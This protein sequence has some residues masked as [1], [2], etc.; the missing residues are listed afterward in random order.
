MN[1]FSQNF[2]LHKQLHFKNRFLY[3]I[4]FS[5]VVALISILFSCLYSY[6]YSK[7]IEVNITTSDQVLLHEVE[8]SI[9]EV[10]DQIENAG[11]Q[12]ALSVTRLINKSKLSLTKDYSRMQQIINSLVNL[13][14]SNSY[15]HSSYVYISSGNMVMTSTVGTIPF[16]LFYDTN[17]KS[18]YDKNT[19]KIT[20]IGP[21]KPY[22]SKMAIYEP[23]YIKNGFDDK[24]VITMI[25]P[26]T[27][28]PSIKGGA[29]IINLY[30]EKI[31]ELMKT[32]SPYNQFL[33]IDI[34]GKIISSPNE[35]QKN[36]IISS[37]IIK[38]LS[39]LNGQSGDFHYQSINGNS[40]ICVFR[41]SAINNYI[42]LDDIDVKK[43]TIFTG[44]MNKYLIIISILFFLV[45][46]IYTIISAKIFYKPIKQLYNLL[47][48]PNSTIGDSENAVS[49][50][51]KLL[52]ENKELH[53]LWDTNK[54]LSK[55]RALTQLLLNSSSQ[56]FTVLKQ[57]EIT[58]QYQNYTC[59]I[60]HINN[61]ING[62]TMDLSDQFELK[63]MQLFPLI[64]QTMNLSHMGYTV[65]FNYLDIAIIF[66]YLDSLN[67][68][69]SICEELKDQINDN[70]GLQ[71]IIG[72]GNEVHS[73]A[74][75]TNSF[76]EAQKV[77][78]YSEDY[79]DSGVIMYS[80]ISLNSNNNVTMLD[81]SA[82]IDD[83]EIGNV[84]GA[85]SRLTNWIENS[86]GS[87]SL[88]SVKNNLLSEFKNLSNTIDAMGISPETKELAN[89]IETINHAKNFEDIKTS[90]SDYFRILNDLINAKK[91]N[92]NSKIVNKVQDFICANYMQNIS[93]N[94][95]AENM[96]LSVPYLCKIYKDSTGNTI[97]DYLMKIRVQY[98]KKLLSDP[99]LK[100]AQISKQVGYEN[101][102]SFIR[103]FKN[104]TNYT[105]SEYR[106]ILSS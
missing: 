85:L 71:A 99:S 100:I 96:Y 36:S 57:S 92:R 90:V 74:D 84:K 61:N 12:E 59:A 56:D 63:R 48:I 64:Q 7:S 49:M 45:V 75:I 66:N 34:N 52:T 38:N 43:L 29:I 31:A 55:Q 20:W 93:L 2:F 11:N 37:Q 27:Q 106:K 77:I 67:S 35:T 89:T 70:I 80:D 53:S 91:D 86:S 44:S 82:V 32:E 28:S 18:I 81:I 101:T 88:S 76:K 6:I 8:M 24:N 69:T 16:S 65:D 30:T 25:L 46:S 51:Q 83:L 3:K 68:I 73:I 4:I 1:T 98:A 23:T 5:L 94:D 42:L 78:R 60:V 79:S 62:D 17:W 54:L 104:A 22:D 15:I 26:L 41:R 10:F 19:N 39:S 95:I 21:R 33:L 13:T 87:C 72:I 9:Q 105:P 14:T 47:N 58:F 97:N 50:V 103:M 40:H 102:Q